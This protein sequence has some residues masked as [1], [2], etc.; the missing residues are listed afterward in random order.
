MN[1]VQIKI[2][3]KIA[4]NPHPSL[5]GCIIDSMGR[6]C[7]C[8]GYRCVKLKVSPP[9]LFH[10]PP[11][12]PLVRFDLL[13]KILYPYISGED[14]ER[15]YPVLSDVEDCG[16]AKKPYVFEGTDVKV[17]PGYLYDMMRMFPDAQIYLGSV[18]PGKKAVR[19]RSNYGVGYLLPMT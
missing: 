17:A 1:Q 9:Q 19:F 12:F 6:Y 16:Y 18:E 13:D 15:V 11:S 8:D 5:R 2:L 14:G 4:D 10:T 7:F 3:Q